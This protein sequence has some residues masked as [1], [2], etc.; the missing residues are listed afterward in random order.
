MKQHWS[1]RLLSKGRIPIVSAIAFV[2]LGLMAFFTF[3]LS[4]LNP[5]RKAVQEFSMTDLYYQILQETG[6]PEISKLITIVDMTELIS[7]R[8]LALSLEDIESRK[9]KVVGVD[10]VFEGRKEDAV[11]DSM[12]AFVASRYDNIIWSKKLYSYTNDEQEHND[13]IRS[14]FTEELT[15]KEGVTNMQR[16]LYGGM[17]RKLSMAW[18]LRGK[19]QPS[20]I[21]AVSNDYADREIA[22]LEA[23]DMEINFTPTMFPVIPADSILMHPELITDHIVLFGAM[24]EEVD[25]HYTPLGKIAGIEL[26]AYGI[27]TLMK[28]NDILEISGFWFWSVTFI[29]VMLTYWFRYR[30]KKWTEARRHASQRLLLGFPLVGSII[31]F[32]WMALLM[33]VAFVLFCAYD[34]SF[35]LGLAFS[36]IAFLSTAESSYNSLLN[37][38]KDLQ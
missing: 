3:N 18:R 8:D 19:L 33:W 34:L 26:L 25:M 22:P 10:M 11:G 24:T 21:A 28:Q 16:Q 15:V 7:R 12:I 36:A 30:R 31:A 37:Y 14:F 20:F 5:I 17:K 23:R 27:Q 35:N 13:D 4:F 6:T 32:L 29:M 38:T 1:Y 9:P 2:V